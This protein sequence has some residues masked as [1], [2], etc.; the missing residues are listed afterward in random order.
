MRCTAL[1]FSPAATARL[2]AVRRSSCGARPGRRAAAAALEDSVPEVG[3]AEETAAGR[4]EDEI[5]GSSV[6]EHRG[7]LF[8][9][10]ELL[11]VA[12]QGAGA[13]GTYNHAR[14]GLTW[15]SDA[16]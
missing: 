7:E 2:A 16:V 11:K 5:V 4:G 3:I 14:R 15:L 6:A 10:R 12:A 1:T 9:E 13:N 8:D